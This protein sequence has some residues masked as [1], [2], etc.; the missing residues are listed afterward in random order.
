[1]EYMEKLL[2]VDDAPKMYLV[3]FSRFLQPNPLCDSLL[4]PPLLLSHLWGDAT[5]P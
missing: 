2:G 3:I 4:T 5:Q 1:M